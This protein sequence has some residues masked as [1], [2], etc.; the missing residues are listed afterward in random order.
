M[1]LTQF[2]FSIL[3][4]FDRKFG[5]N[6]ERAVQNAAQIEEDI[7]TVKLKSMLCKAL[8]LNVLDSHTN[9]VVDQAEDIQI[10]FAYILKCLSLY[11]LNHEMY[12]NWNKHVALFDQAELTGFSEKSVTELH[13]FIQSIV[14]TEHE[15]N[16]LSLEKMQQP[17]HL[18]MLLFI[19]LDAILTLDSNMEPLCFT[20]LFKFR[21]KKN[22]PYG[23]SSSF[24]DFIIYSLASHANKKPLEKLPT[25]SSFD[26]YLNT[27]LFDDDSDDGT[28]HPRIKAM[29]QLLKKMRAE[30][31]FCYLTDIDQ[32]FTTPFDQVK[33]MFDDLYE[34][35]TESN[36]R[37]LLS[38]TIKDDDFVVFNEINAL[39]L[40]YYFQ[41]I[42][43]EA[44][45]MNP[46]EV[47]QGLS[48]T[49]EFVDVWK[50]FY[51]PNGKKATFQWPRQFNDIAKIT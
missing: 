46:P 29:R 18:I 13:Q 22:K 23:P 28:E 48:S 44:Q 6:L 27:E 11:P 31:R 30:D 16:Y 17:I 41:Y 51:V 33:L 38:R 5:E 24:S 32:F 50:M 15:H 1:N 12:Q 2:H 40:I 47:L 45:K 39:W 49:R 8:E 9:Q 42:I 7:S 35:I 3:K 10:T 19:H 26:K 14:V 25:I 20:Q 37:F 4:K 21:L 34:K 36:S 43:Y